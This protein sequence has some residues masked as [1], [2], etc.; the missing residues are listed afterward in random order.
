MREARQILSAIVDYRV[1]FLALEPV[2]L[3]AIELGAFID[4]YCSDPLVE[5]VK[6]KL[7]PT[8]TRILSL[9]ALRNR[10]RFSYKIHRVLRMLVTDPSFSSSSLYQHNREVNSANPLMRG[11][12]RMGGAFP[13]VRGSRVN[14]FLRNTYGRISPTI[15]RSPRILAPSRTLVPEFLCSQRLKIFT[16]VES[17]DHAGKYPSGFVSENVFVWNKDLGHDWL[18]YQGDKTYTVGYPMKHRY[19]V[20]H[21]QKNKAIVPPAKKRSV[22]MYAPAFPSQGSNK[23]AYAEELAQIEEICLVAKEHNA[24]LFLK[25]KPQGNSRDFDFLL[26]KFSNLVI[27]SYKESGQRPEDYYL[28]SEYNSHR[29]DEL[30]KCDLLI[31]GGTTFGIDAA[32]YGL[33]VLQLDFRD[34]KKYPAIAKAFRNYHLEK[35]FLSDPSMTLPVMGDAT[36]FDSLNSYLKAPDGK[37]VK[38]GARLKEWVYTNEAFESAM[39]RIANTMLAD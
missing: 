19:V 17:W 31:N 10:H 13:K 8:S 12:Y 38:F 2:M 33:P 34:S 22:L 4:I 30:G 6:S 18:K 1:N 3:A 27:G 21:A 9:D 7:P 36:L 16:V 15:F 20:E 28:D 25:P 32:I 37:E 26:A 11:L 5:L 29:L 39:R 24:T 35:Y 14:A 23:T